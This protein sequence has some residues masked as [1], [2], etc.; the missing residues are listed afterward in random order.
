MP[1]ERFSRRQFLNVLLGGGLFAGL[2][3]SFYAAARY[4]IPPDIP[5]ASPSTV[6]AARVGELDP[7]TAKIFRFGAKPGLLLRLPDGSYR[8]FS[9]VCTHLD[10][11][12]QYRADLGHIWCACHD[13]HFD[14]NGVNI[15]GPPPKPL[16]KFSVVIKGEDVLVSKEA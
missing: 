5:E 7:D 11:T 1:K 10:C 14:L 3:A 8:A 2:C 16:D 6:V 12:V 9:G 4:L 13:G 15:S